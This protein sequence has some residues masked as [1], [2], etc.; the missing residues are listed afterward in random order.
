MKEGAASAVTL[1]N[2]HMIITYTGS[3]DQNKR[4]TKTKTKQTKGVGGWE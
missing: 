3:A 4:E 1:S 2:F